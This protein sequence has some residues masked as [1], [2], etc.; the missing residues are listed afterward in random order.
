MASLQEPRIEPM[1][2]YG[3]ASQEVC[4][5]PM[6]QSHFEVDVVSMVRPSG[7]VL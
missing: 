1:R 7:E 3:A 6:Q 4:R 2:S 5:D